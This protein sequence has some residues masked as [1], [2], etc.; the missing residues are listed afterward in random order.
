MRIGPYHL[1]SPVILAPMAGVTDLPFRRLCRRYGAGLAVSEMISSRPQL[2]R[3]RR[4][5][6]RAN[7]RG[8]PEP[9]AVQILG[10]DP[11]AMAACARLAE[12]QGAQI[13]DINMGCPAKKV[14]RVA[15][16]SALL[17]DEP[18]VAAILTAV[19]QAVTVP[20]TLKIRTGWDPAHR[21]AVTIARLAEDAGI[22]MLAVHGRTRACGFHGEAE[23]DTIA[24]VKQA[25]SIPVVANG[26]IDSPEKARRVLDHTGADAVMIGRAAQGQPWLLGQVAAGLEGR[27]LPA[28]G[29]TEKARVILA[30]VQALHAFYGP[31]AGVRIARK[32]IR[33][34]L[35]RL[36]L[37]VAAWRPLL[38][39]E[40]AAAQLDGLARLLEARQAA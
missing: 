39:Q 36:G 40:A 32:H 22:C 14:C 11:G 21:N 13:I 9:R 20:V 26:D 33:W 29:W 17:R 8:E 2:Q 18:R 38:Q 1:S 7:H 34:Y 37:P 6:Q 25:V 24:E 19:V 23:Y 10:V 35:E 3:H 4:T 30:H 16:G 15:A 27:R 28:P 5:R 31:Q 12:A